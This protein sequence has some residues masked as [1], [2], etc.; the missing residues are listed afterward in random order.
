MMVQVFIVDA[1]DARGMNE[2]WREVFSE[3]FPC[4]ATVVV[5]E[6]L[7]PGMRIEMVA[8]AHLGAV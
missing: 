1:A 6:L 4:R 2:V 3:P 5:K 8:T 7:S